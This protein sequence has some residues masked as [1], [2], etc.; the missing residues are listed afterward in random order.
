MFPPVRMRARVRVRPGAWPKVRRRSTS[1]RPGKIPTRKMTFGAGRNDGSELCD[2]RGVQPR[3]F[4]PGPKLDAATR[5]AAEILIMLS[6]DACQT[7]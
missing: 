1:E 5:P 2:R 3:A 7:A 4:P 6:E